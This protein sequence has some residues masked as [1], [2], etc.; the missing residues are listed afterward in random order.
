[1]EEGWM[2]KDILRIAISIVVSYFVLW[3]AGAMFNFFPFRADDLAI[4]AIG[5]TGLMICLVIVGCACWIIH[6]IKKK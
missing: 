6:E 5:F 4:S 3:Y 2:E 1:M